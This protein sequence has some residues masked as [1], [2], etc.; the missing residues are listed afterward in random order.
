MSQS[1][2]Q[3][4]LFDWS[5]TLVDDL[6]PVLE[7]TNAVMREFNAKELTVED[8]RRGFRLPYADWYEEVLPG[9]SLE[10]LGRVFLAS[11]TATK[12]VVGAHPHVR[13]Y[14]DCCAAAGRRMF[15]LSSTFESAVQAQAES[16]DLGRYF[17]HIYAGVPDK[18]ARIR[19]ILEERALRP[20]Q[21]ILIGDMRH[22]VHTAKAGGIGSVAVLTGYEYGDVIATA[23]PDLIV[24][25]LSELRAL[26]F[27]ADS[28]PA[29]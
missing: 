25:D 12:H 19:G 27:P 3:N 23:G 10:E 9:V 7:A 15:V 18:S 26:H 13:E 21:T 22:D 8:F 14:L 2:I 29:S 20:E 28:Q 5:G 16:L 1:S 24:K 6:P 17:E 11:F 4:I